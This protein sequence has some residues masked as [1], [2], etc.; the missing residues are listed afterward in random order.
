[1]RTDP[2]FDSDHITSHVIASRSLSAAVIGLALATVSCFPQYAFLSVFPFLFLCLKG[3]HTSLL[4]G[5][6]IAVVWGAWQLLIFSPVYWWSP[7]HVYLGLY[8]IN[9]PI[10]TYYVLLPLICAMWYGVYSP[11]D[12]H[13]DEGP[14]EAAEPAGQGGAGFAVGNPI[15]GMDIFLERSGMASTGG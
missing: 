13:I 10:S 3:F 15:V 5:L 12:I 8:G 14:C 4:R 1:M 7:P 2:R 11:L 6:F 9:P